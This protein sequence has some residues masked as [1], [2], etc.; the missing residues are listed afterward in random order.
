MKIRDLKLSVYQ[1][2]WSS[3]KNLHKVNAREDVE[4]TL[5]HCCWECNWCSHYGG[6]C[7]YSLKNLWWNKITIW[8]KNPTTGHIL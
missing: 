6:Q 4:K 3:L 8:L 7:G 5:L 2:E 1:S